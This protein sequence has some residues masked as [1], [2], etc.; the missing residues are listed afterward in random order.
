LL[1]ALAVLLLAAQLIVLY[2]HSIEVNQTYKPVHLTGDLSVT[3]VDNGVVA[4]WSNI[5]SNL[6]TGL[7]LGMKAAGKAT[8]NIP[9]TTDLSESTTVIYIDDA[10]VPEE[11]VQPQ[12]MQVDPTKDVVVENPEVSSEHER[13]HEGRAEERKDH[14]HTNCKL[15]H[16]IISSSCMFPRNVGADSCPADFFPAQF[17][18][19]FMCLNDK[20]PCGQNQ[21]CAKVMRSMIKVESATVTKNIEIDGVVAVTPRVIAG[22]VT[23]SESDK[24]DMDLELQSFKF[25]PIAILPLLVPITVLL[26]QTDVYLLVL[27][28]IRAFIYCK[29]NRVLAARTAEDPE[30]SPKP[31]RCL[32]LLVSVSDWWMVLMYILQAFIT[33][34]V[35]FICFYQYDEYVLEVVRGQC[36]N[37][38]AQR[39]LFA[40]SNAMNNLVLVPLFLICFVVM[41]VV[42]K[43]FYRFIKA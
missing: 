36:F 42:S 38:M 23:T 7:G 31:S 9:D 32:S 41:Y 4:T 16:K 25:T 27:L 29:Y 43:A 15:P 19:V 40:V 2:D 11:V 18:T 30:S 39:W 26:L 17:E 21:I 24:L 12:L 8:A 13:R 33:A 5:A 10:V 14:H 20:K 22:V 37:H 34:V 3:P 1:W 28:L 6:V 35:V